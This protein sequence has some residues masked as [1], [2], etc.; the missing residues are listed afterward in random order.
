MNKDDNGKIRGNF[1]SLEELGQYLKE[2]PAALKVVTNDKSESCLECEYIRSSSKSSHLIFF[3][4][5]LIGKF[6]EF[7]DLFGDNTYAICPNIPG[8][9]QVLVLLGKKYNVVSNIM[10]VSPIHKWY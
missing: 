2:N 6:E 8:V 7:D 10:L 3:S 4:T 9:G 1:S 5:E